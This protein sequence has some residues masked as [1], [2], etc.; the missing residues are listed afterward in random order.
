MTEF[1]LEFTL[2]QRLAMFL[3]LAAV[4]W[5]LVECFKVRGEPD[6]ASIGPTDTPHEI[7]SATQWSIYIK[8]RLEPEE[9]VRHSSR[10]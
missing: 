8:S 9:L 2:G 10:D 4:A 6:S 3:A 7:G 1:L 5:L